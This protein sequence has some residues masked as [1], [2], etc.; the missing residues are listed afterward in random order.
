MKK[1]KHPVA[2][3]AAAIIVAV[4]PTSGRAQI[5]IGT[6]PDASYA[7]I[8]S[9]GDPLIYEYRYNFDPSKPLDGYDLLTAIDSAV[10]ELH[11]R[12][13]NFGDDESPN[14]I[15]DSITFGTETLTNTAF[16][17]IGPFWAQWVSGGKAGFP[18]AEPIPADAW[19]FGSG[20]SSP[21]RSIAP[22]SSDG[23][24]FNDG[25]TPP[26]VGPI[27]EPQ[28]LGLL[29]AGITVVLWMLRRRHEETRL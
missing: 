1:V 16:P 15:L 11:L 18:T 28:S 2:A 19:S 21:Y 24:V 9:F 17:N 12:F 25:D 27:P 7:V 4:F 13:N 10:P 3:L 29:L 23:F 22:G 5:V 6:G 26:T 14:Y 20:V 8:D